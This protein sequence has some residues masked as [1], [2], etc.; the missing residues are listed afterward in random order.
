M[1]GAP[2][3]HPGQA[4]ETMRVRDGAPDERCRSRRLAVQQRHQNRSAFNGYHVTWSRY[5]EVVCLDCGC[6]WRTTAAYVDDLP[7]GRY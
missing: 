4:W 6:R 3:P 2:D 7:D 1:T 5:S